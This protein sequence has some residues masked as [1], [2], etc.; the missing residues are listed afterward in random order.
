M[1]QAGAVRLNAIGAPTIVTPS[2]RIDPSAQVTFAAASFLIL[3]ARQPMSRRTV[4]ELLWPTATNA[5][6]AH[7]LRQTLLKLRRLGLNVR[8]VG[9]T[10]VMIDASDVSADFESWAPEDSPRDP[11]LIK[12]MPFGGYNP[13]IS[14]EFSEWLEKQR[15]LITSVISHALLH[16]IST[17]DSRPSGLLLK[18]GVQRFCKS[19]H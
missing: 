1:K 4:E 3:E 13:H 19:L 7:R 10:Q 5:Q 16:R 11:R 15:T 12:L 2:G 8:S 18:L 14:V 9:K 17:T 6:A